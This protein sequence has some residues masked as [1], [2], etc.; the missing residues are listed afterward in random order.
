M[1]LPHYYQHSNGTIKA[2]QPN[3]DSKVPFK[4]LSIVVAAF[5]SDGGK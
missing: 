3:P 1:C 4:L 5:A 2:S